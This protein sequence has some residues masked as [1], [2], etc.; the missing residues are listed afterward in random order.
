MGTELL[1]AREAFIGHD[2]SRAELEL[3]GMRIDP[4]HREGEA[5]LMRSRWFDYADMHPVAA[6]Y[7]FAHL[8]NEQTRRFYAAC[9]DERTA[10]DQVGFTPEDIFYSRDLTAM[11]LARRCADKNGWP[12]DFV[13]EVAQK[14]FID[15]LFHR[16]PR[17]NQLYS[18]EFELDLQDEWR[19]RLARQLV[20]SRAPRF[21][22]M[23]FTGQVVQ[24]RHA[25]FVIEQIKSRV[26]PHTGLL[27]RM[28]HEDVLSVTM[29]AT[30][31]KPDEVCA[32]L[33]VAADL[34]R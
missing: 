18:E 28:L 17:P 16:F 26:R 11:W 20:Y 19:A 25:N 5:D 12:Y 10:A 14:R 3:R 9:I 29:A 24:A 32:A 8:Y 7:L 21:K 27:G 13:L 1:T 15:K 31:F 23:N 33:E 30:R 4:V 6:T 34:A 2:L 22:A